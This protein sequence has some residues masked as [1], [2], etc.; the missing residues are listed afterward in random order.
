MLES[1]SMKKLLA[2]IVLGLL[3]SE[4][5]YAKKIKALDIIY[6]DENNIHIMVP[7]GLSFKPDKIAVQHCSSFN[8][9]TYQTKGNAGKKYY[10]NKGYK[11]PFGLPVNV[12]ICSKENI[13]RAPNNHK[14]SPSVGLIA[15]NILNSSTAPTTVK[16]NEVKE[17]DMA[18]MI[19]KAKNTCKSLGF[20]EGSEK[21]SDCSLKLYSQSVELAAEQNKTVVMQ[22]QSSGSNKMT[23]YD[24]VRDANALIK[25]GQRMMSGAC[26]LGINC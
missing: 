12:Y 23:I 26:T 24:P 8:K 5:A 9:S 25:Q 16:N 19:N 13:T 21:F 15:I 10:K 7:G 6:K 17:M 22:Q 2:I 4:S 11:L 3:F 20:K 18:S 14:I 1:W